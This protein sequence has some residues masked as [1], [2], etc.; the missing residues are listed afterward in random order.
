MIPS[1]V[2]TRPVGLKAAQLRPCDARRSAVRLLWAALVRGSARH[3]KPRGRR[4]WLASRRCCQTHGNLVTPQR[5]LNG[6]NMEETGG[7]SVYGASLAGGGFDFQKFVKQPQT[8]VRLLS[9]VSAIRMAEGSGDSAGCH[10]VSKGSARIFSC[11][12]AV[13]YLYLCSPEQQASLQGASC[14]VQLV[15]NSSSV[16]AHVSTAEDKT[17]TCV[18]ET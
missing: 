13:K 6:S 12:G 4:W 9:W 2:P 15:C 8:I 10:T 3:V 16:T 17:H 1:V 11:P 7:T 14:C 18:G 5:R